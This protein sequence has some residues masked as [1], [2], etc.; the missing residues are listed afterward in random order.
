MADRPL[1]ITR[2]EGDDLY[3]LLQRRTLDELQRLSGEVWSDYNPSDSGVTVADAVD[4]ALTETDYKL[5]FALEDYLS[6]PDGT[7]QVGRYGLFP[8]SEVYPSA[9][10]TADDYRKLVLARFPMVQNVAVTADTDKCAY[11]FTLRLSPYFND[12][13]GIVKRIRS[14]LNRHRNLC[15]HIGRIEVLHPKELTFS[16]EL[17]ILPGYNATEILVRIY[18]TAMQY[19]SGSVRLEMDIPG[20]P[21]KGYGFDTWY[22]GP[23]KDVRVTIPRQAD[24][25]REL[26]WRLCGIEGV[27][28]FKTCWFKD[29]GGHIVTDFSGGYALAIPDDCKEVTVL[30]GGERADIDMDELKERLKALYFMRSTLRMRDFMQK[31]G[32]GMQEKDVPVQEAARKARYRNVYGHYPVAGDL[33]RCYRTSEKDFPGSATGK[34]KAEAVNFGSYLSLFDLL[35]ERGMGELKGLRR[36]LSLRDTDSPSHVPLLADKNIDIKRLKNRQRDVSALKNRY[37]DFLDGLYGVES[38]PVWLREFE[39]YGSSEDDR[40]RRRMAFLR[41]VPRLLR[42]RLKGMDVTGTYGG[43][44]VPTVK[45]W[46]SLLLDF[47]CSEEI[48]V[49][50]ILPG[51][52]LILMGDGECG[53]RVRELMSSSMID[54][55]LFTADTVE[56]VEPDEPPATEAEKLDRDEELRRNLPIFNS[57]WISGSLFREGIRL[58]AYNLVRTWN[59]EWLLVFQGREERLRMNLGR[60]DDK[61][62]LCRWANTLCRYLR[63]LNR[64]CEAVYVVEKSL[65]ESAEPLTVFLVFTGW[66]ARTRSMRFRNACEQLARSVLPAHIRMETCW[67]RASQMQRFEECYRKWRDCLAGRLPEDMKPLLQKAMM[68]VIEKAAVSGQGGSAA[69]PDMEK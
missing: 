52:N 53:Q 1:Y 45:C 24:T 41:E 20:S 50:N 69:A 31:H 59:S 57:N 54:D 68:T 34:E 5:G 13:D 33:P 30:T 58:S 44:N 48:S 18:W 32:R 6:D 23:V 46:L 2:P 42:D 37:M 21:E 36:L 17:E 66:T 67:L 61:K 7:W 8:A 38:A 56:T 51:H 3:T 26:Y 4:Y 14:F 65:F 39:Y 28:Y 43:E 10:V 40:L 12:E 11:D 15:E 22:D 19:L 63:E 27:K 49:G 64:Q 47:N 35:M 55:S 29:L 60:S 25:Q 16:A 62:K 9:P